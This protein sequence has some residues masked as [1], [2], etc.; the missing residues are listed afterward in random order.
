MTSVE[1][2]VPNNRFLCRWPFVTLPRC[3]IE[4]SP[5]LLLPTLPRSTSFR[6]GPFRARRRN[7]L[8]PSLLISRR[9]WWCC[10]WWWWWRCCWASEC[11]AVADTSSIWP[12][13][14][15]D[16]Y[17][18]ADTPNNSLLSSDNSAALV[19]V[20]KWQGKSRE[21]KRHKLLW[22]KKEVQK[23]KEIWEENHFFFKR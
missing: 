13:A 12:I 18:D 8:L 14:D 19:P 6:D 9:R 15:D 4:E 17:C 20:R 3:F 2:S 16:V 23:K 7:E 1:L 5:L 10:L 21:K 22:L 11:W